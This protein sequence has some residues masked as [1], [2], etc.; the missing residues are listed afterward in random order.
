MPNRR[1]ILIIEDDETLLNMLAEYLEETQ[2][3][4][5]SKAAEHRCGGRDPRR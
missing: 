5:V 1:P 2:E 4:N 3:F